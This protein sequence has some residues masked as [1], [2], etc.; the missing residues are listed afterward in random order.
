[1]PAFASSRMLLA[2]YILSGVLCAAAGVFYAARQ[3]STNS[4]TGIGWEFQ[5]LTA[6]IIGVLG[7]RRAWLMPGGL[8]S[9]RSSSS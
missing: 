7:A 8:R 6:V 2:T 9:A 4:T 1:M 5:A 3:G